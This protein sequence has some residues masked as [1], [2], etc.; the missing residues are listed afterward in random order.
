MAL[1]PATLSW[2]LQ[3]LQEGSIYINTI[4]SK[5][6]FVS[7]IIPAEGLQEVSTGGGLA[8]QLLC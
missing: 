5:V 3:L 8:M 2:R 1:P 7:L 6:C 4:L